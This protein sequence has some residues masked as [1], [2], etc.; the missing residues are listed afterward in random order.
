MRD[1]HGGGGEHPDQ[2]EV[3]VSSGRQITQCI[4]TASARY[5]G[6]YV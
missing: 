4:H 6:N 1:Q 2:V 5:Q 3:I